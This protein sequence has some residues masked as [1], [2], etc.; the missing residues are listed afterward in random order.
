[1]DDDL[2]DL[3]DIKVRHVLP[4]DIIPSLFCKGTVDRKK[5]IL[6]SFIWQSSLHS[7]SIPIGFIIMNGKGWVESR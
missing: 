7:F 6:A 5:E 1:M 3:C 2:I 4:L